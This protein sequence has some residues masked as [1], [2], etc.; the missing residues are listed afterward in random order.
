MSGITFNLSAAIKAHGQDVETLELS[1]P[2]TKDVRELGYPFSP[3]TG[4]E[5]GMKLHPDIGARWISRLAKI[6]MSSVDQMEPGDFLELHA[7]LCGFFTTGAAPTSSK[8]VSTT[9]PGS[10]T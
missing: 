10:G 4:G 9:A 7:E 1:K 6:P 8:S 2:T 5:G 3:S